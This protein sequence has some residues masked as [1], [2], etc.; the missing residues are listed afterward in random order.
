MSIPFSNT[1][2]RIP[3]GFGNLL[4]GL[5]REILR[6][7]PDN[8]PAFAAAYFENLLEKREKTNFDPAEWGAKVD[9][10]FYN[11]HAFKESP[12][13][14]KDMEE[15][16]AL[17]IQAAFRGHLAREEV[18]KMKSSDLEEEKTEENE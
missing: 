14:D 6:E 12:E 11:N 1:H 13:E 3:Q 8:I 18:K 2:Y 9:D 7:Q 17:K 16:A 15:N 4:E 5:T 10:R